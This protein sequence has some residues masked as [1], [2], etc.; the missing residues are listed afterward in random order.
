MEEI[1]AQTSNNAS[2]ANEAN[3]LANQAKE[4]ANIGNNK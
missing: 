1:S 3:M 4:Y 2:N